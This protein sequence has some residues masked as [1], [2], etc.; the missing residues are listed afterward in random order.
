MSSAF[1][2]RANAEPH[3]NGWAGRLL[4]PSAL[5]RTVVEALDPTTGAVLETRE[6]R[7]N[8]LPLNPL[9][10]IYMSDTD[11]IAASELEQRILYHIAVNLVASRPAQPYESI[12][13]ASRRGRH[14]ISAWKNFWS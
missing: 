3:L 1:G 4:G 6:M 14:A 10:M 11:G 12:Q 13:R 8:E 9:D 2:F 7:L 5:V